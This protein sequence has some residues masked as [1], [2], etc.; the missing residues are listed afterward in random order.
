MND[1][2]IL[3]RLP[4]VAAPEG[5]ESLVLAALNEQIRTAP[6]RR[7]ARVLRWVT[8]GTLA[9]VIALFAGLNLFVLRGPDRSALSA[10]LAAGEPVSLDEHVDYRREVRTAAPAPGTVYILEQ[11]SDASHTLYKY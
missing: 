10:E 3:N 9:A 8:A 6:V 5:F 4:H 7:R 1:S 11:V 2:E